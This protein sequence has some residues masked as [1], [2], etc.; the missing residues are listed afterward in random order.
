M[1]EPGGDAILGSPSEHCN[2]REIRHA[3]ERYHERQKI[4]EPACVDVERILRR[5]D[6][7]VGQRIRD[8]EALDRPERER[9]LQNQNTGEEGYTTRNGKEKRPPHRPGPREAGQV[10][11]DA[12][13]NHALREP[14]DPRRAKLVAEQLEDR[15]PR[16]DQDAIEIARLYEVLAEYVAPTR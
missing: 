6:T 11:A 13:G 7:T 4:P 8:L 9:R 14:S 3:R 1:R 10:H 12:P 15:P 16:A 2:Y 5:F